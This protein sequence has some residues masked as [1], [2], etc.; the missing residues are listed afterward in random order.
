[1]AQ[2]LSCVQHTMQKVAGREWGAK[3]LRVALFCLSN[4]RKE[5]E[6]TKENASISIQ[7]SF[8]ER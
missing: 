2:D 6:R 3:L 4:A 1:M 5:A 8:Y 7:N